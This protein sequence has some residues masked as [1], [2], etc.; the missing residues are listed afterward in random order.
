MNTK[1][2]VLYVEYNE[3]PPAILGS[4]IGNNLEELDGML[5]ISNDKVGQWKIYGFGHLGPLNGCG[6]PDEDGKKKLVT[7]AEVGEC[8]ALKEGDELNTST[9]EEAG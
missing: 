2:K 1:M 6:I 5:F 4:L 8:Q 7:I 9:T 3:K